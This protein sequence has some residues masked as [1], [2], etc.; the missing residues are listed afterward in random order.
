[1][2]HASNNYIPSNKTN[3]TKWN[4]PNRIPTGPQTIKT[5]KIN[6]RKCA[7]TFFWG[8][9]HPINEIIIS[10]VC[11]TLYRADKRNNIQ[12]PFIHLLRGKGYTLS[13]PQSKV[14]SQ[15]KII[16]RHCKI[17]YTSVATKTVV[18]KIINLTIKRNL[19][20]QPSTQSG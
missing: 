5:K 13:K 10:N 1:M 16:F 14:H 18:N 3:E 19:P 20:L 8:P 2:K 15:T 6:Q 7:H 11:T 4:P 17:Q 9:S 12:K